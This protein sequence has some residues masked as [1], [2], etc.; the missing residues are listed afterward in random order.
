MTERRMYLVISRRD[1]LS[2]LELCGD[3]NG[4]ATTVILD[5]EAQTDYQNQLQFN[6]QGMGGQQ[7]RRELQSTNAS[8]NAENLKVIDVSEPEVG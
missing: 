4:P 2:L 1:L 5:L 6:A 8:K 3:S 7:G